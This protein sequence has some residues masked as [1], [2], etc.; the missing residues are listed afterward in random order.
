PLPVVAR[1]L[2]HSN[3]SMTMR[4]AHV[5]DRE[6][7][8]AA[9]RVGQAVHTLIAGAAITGPDRSEPTTRAG[10]AAD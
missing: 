8:A 6:I 4:Y 2:G 5:G 7:E 10:A 3:V 1:L 9:E